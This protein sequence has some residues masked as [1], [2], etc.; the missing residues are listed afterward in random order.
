MNFLE[1]IFFGNPIRDWLIA[2]GI[3]I[4]AFAA[5]KIFKGPVLR[6]LE[7]WSKKTKNTFDDFVV[8]AIEKEVVPFLYFAALF[9]ALQYLAFST[10]VEH[11]I[12]VAMM[13]V[14]T[15][16][17]LRFISSAIQYSVFAFLAKQ[18][19]SETK[20]KQARGL[21]IILKVTIWILGMVFLID[22]LGY[23]VTTIITGLGI[24]GIA[25]ALAAQ[26]ILGD[27]FSYFVIFFDRPF[28]IGDFIIVDDKTIGAIEY[29][30]VKTTRIRAISGEQ[31]I[32]GNKNLTDSRVHNYKRMLK[33][34]VVFS[35][36]VTYQ[37]SP[38]IMRKIPEMIKDIIV[39]KENVT[40]D[41]CNF[42]GFGDFSLNFETVYIID[43]ADYNI[44]MNLQENIYLEILEKFNN[45]KIDFAYPTQTL[46]AANSFLQQKEIKIN[47]LVSTFPEN[48]GNNS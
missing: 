2:A 9:G 28:E 1:R 12:Q 7:K 8:M 17:I 33:R 18:E 14:T 27:L 40:F 6:R 36:G 4:V 46:F 19:N 23:N 47:G 42:S 43:G 35:L 21:L 24:G 45:E 30:G 39:S 44:Y 32:C 15:F 10:H 29:I 22:N 38:D 5:I 3:I 41:R 26:A 13:F 31:I 25:I 20:Q 48:N 37:T 11:V 16:F 34:R